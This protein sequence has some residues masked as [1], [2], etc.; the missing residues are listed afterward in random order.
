MLH[1][2][3]SKLISCVPGFHFPHS[4]I[5]NR[6]YNPFPLRLIGGEGAPMTQNPEF[7]KDNEY[8]DVVSTRKVGFEEK[9]VSKHY[10][11][12]DEEPGKSGSKTDTKTT[13]QFYSPLFETPLK[14]HAVNFARQVYSIFQNR[15][16][17]LLK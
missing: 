7:E 2:C 17:Y 6:R 1:M 4:K 12:N 5:A 16:E 10:F 3:F 15:C 14:K 9:K 11:C 8:R 13:G